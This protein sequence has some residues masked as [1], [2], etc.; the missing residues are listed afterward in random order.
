VLRRL[1][2]RIAARVAMVLVVRLAAAYQKSA[3]SIVALGTPI[4]IGMGLN[5]EPILRLAFGQKWLGAVDS[6]AAI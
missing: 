5:A 3:A 4:M 1:D 2:Y 6:A